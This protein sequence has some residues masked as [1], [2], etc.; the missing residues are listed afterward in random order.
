VAC[1]LFTFV[2]DERVTGPD[3]ELTWQASHALAS[4]QSYLGIQDAGRKARPSSQTPGAW[5]GAI[6]HV[7]PSL[8]VC[9]LTSAEKWD[10]MKGILEKWWKQVAGSN[11]PKLSHKEL[12]SDRGFLVYVTRTYPT[13]VPYLKGFH[14]TIEMWRGGRD[15]DVRPTS[16][17]KMRT[18]THLSSGG[19]DSRQSY[20]TP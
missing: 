3:E 8:G 9:V 14:L 19:K 2:D 20:E 16:S 13:M 18:H 4:K 12:L 6:V 10:K 15:T 17:T 11:V 1:D 5:A 7:L